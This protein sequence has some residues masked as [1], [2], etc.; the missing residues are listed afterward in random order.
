MRLYT[1]PLCHHFMLYFIPGFIPGLCHACTDWLYIRPITSVTP[2]LM[3]SVRPWPRGR[4]PPG[5]PFSWIQFF[6]F[7]LWWLMPWHCSA[8]C[9]CYVALVRGLP[10]S[11]VL[12]RISF[13][14]YGY[15]TNFMQCLYRALCVSLCT[16][17]CGVYAVWLCKKLQT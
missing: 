3:N 6:P 16:S 11:Y 12:F 14:S 1:M 15:F 5:R 10:G 13:L 2:F 9:W 8:L 17:L 7:A 4:S